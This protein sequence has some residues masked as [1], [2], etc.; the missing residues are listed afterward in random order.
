MH[1]GPVRRG[2]HV[3]ASA[4]HTGHERARI[5]LLAWRSTRRRSCWVPMREERVMLRTTMI[6]LLSALAPAGV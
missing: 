2:V 4:S 5:A 1:P 6:R 3:R